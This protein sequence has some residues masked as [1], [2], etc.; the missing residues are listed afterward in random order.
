MLLFAWKRDG[1]S[2]GRR[3]GEKIGPDVRGE[4]D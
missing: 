2:G 3:G 4:R 1:G